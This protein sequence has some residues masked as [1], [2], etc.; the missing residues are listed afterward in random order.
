MSNSFLNRSAVVVNTIA[1]TIALAI[2]SGQLPLSTLAHL[3][4]PL[5]IN[6]SPAQPNFRR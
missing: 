5:N 4:F 6:S 2:L 3:P 1:I